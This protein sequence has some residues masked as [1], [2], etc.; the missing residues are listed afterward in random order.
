[1]PPVRGMVARNQ[2]GRSPVPRGDPGDGPYGGRRRVGS[3]P[4]REQ[5]AVP[6][7]GPEARFTRL[8]LEVLTH[9]AT[10]RVRGRSCEK[11]RMT[12]VNRRALYS[13]A[14]GEALGPGSAIGSRPSWSAVAIVGN[15]SASS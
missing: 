6:L 12:G 5:I 8:E 13:A 9:A 14:R 11:E 1:T 7:S 3:P 2:T 10:P 4:A 15:S